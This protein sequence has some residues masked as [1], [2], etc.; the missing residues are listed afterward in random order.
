[1]GADIHQADILSWAASYDGPPFHALL[2]D[3]P[4][5]LTE[6]VKRFGAADAAPAQFGTDGAFQ[7]ASKGFM[8]KTW[9]GGDLAFRPETWAAL[10]ALLYPGAF[11]MAFAGSRGWHRM[12]VAIEDAGLII[13]PTIFGWNYLSGFPKAT[14]IDTQLD[15]RAGAEREIIGRKK[16][17]PKFDAAGHG[18]R[19]KDNGYNSRE[20]EDFALTAPATELAAAWQGH[21][22]GLQA[23][24]PAL[25]PII[26][27]QRPYEGAP[28]ESIAATGA[29]AFNIDGGRIV[30][31]DG[32]QKGEFGPHH[33]AHLGKA[34]TNGT[35][36]SGFAR[37]DADNTV[38]RWPAN[39]ALSHH[40]AC[41]GV[42]HEDCAVRRLGAQ[43]GESEAKAN[44]RGERHGVI[45]G[46]GNGPSGPDTLRGHS[47]SGTA[48][49]M[50]FNA[51][52]MYERLELA[53]SVGYF[54]KCATGEREAGLDPMQVALMAALAGDEEGADFPLTR[55]TDGRES[56]HE[57]G[58]LRTSSR[59]NTHPT[60]KP[61]ALARWLATLL[62]PPDAYAPR[63]LLV[64]FAGAASEMIGAMLAGWDEITGVELMPEHV[65]IA[66]AR[67]A[68][69]RQRAHAFSDGR[70]ITVKTAPPAPTGQ[71]SLFDGP[72]EAA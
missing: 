46:N 26:V 22:Y 2:C 54:A 59:R 14:R 70:P 51:D 34:T 35:Y 7:R 50:F 68:Y 39:F 41:N 32:D 56:E 53:D 17:A 24:K 57:T 20:R 13:H 28:V 16:H 30:L 52:W 62:L 43:S 27:F 25:E 11:G 40:P 63:R 45:Y 47:D 66:R 5:H 60:I 44:M 21:R 58:H 67:L 71:R 12:A 15:R 37:A 1:M 69:W 42:C 72:S 48:A 18:Y 55:R 65:A 10:G 31:R 23:L 19:E 9:D 38:G 4:Y 33:P 49:R 6:T 3:P 8:G 29:G 64:P 36:G 61:L